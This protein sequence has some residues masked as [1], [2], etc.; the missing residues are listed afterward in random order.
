MV[1]PGSVDAAVTWPLAGEILEMLGDECEVDASFFEDRWTHGLSPAVQKHRRQREQSDAEPT[2]DYSL[3]ELD[4]LSMWSWMQ[5]RTFA[6]KP[7]PTACSVAPATSY[8]AEW[9]QG[10]SEKTNVGFTEPAKMEV[11]TVSDN[12]VDEMGVVHPMTQE[13]ACKL[14]QLSAGSVDVQIKAAYRKLVNQCHPDR[15]ECGNAFEQALA[16]ERMAAINEAYRMLRS[17]VSNA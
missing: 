11:S 7:L 2:G 5:A 1:A 15:F 12:A 8:R 6:E 9:L 16:N 14:L 4:Q 17:A 10:F 3:A 13:S